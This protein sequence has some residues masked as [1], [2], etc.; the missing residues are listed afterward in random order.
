MIFII[1][2]FAEN[3]LQTTKWIKKII[4]GHIIQYTCSFFKQVT[5]C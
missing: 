5:I 2:E 4:C 1:L 3:D